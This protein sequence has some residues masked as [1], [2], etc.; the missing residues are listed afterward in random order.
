MSNVARWSR[1]LTAVFGAVVILLLGL[2]FVRAGVIHDPSTALWP[3]YGLLQLDALPGAQAPET[4]FPYGVHVL[5]WTAALYGVL[6][7]FQRA[8][9]R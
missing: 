5:I 6:A 3:T 1:L 4:W 7:V 2:F 8:Q 9:K